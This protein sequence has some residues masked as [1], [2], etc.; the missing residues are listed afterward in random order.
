ML[1]RIG[2]GVHALA[3]TTGL[4]PPA[5]PRGDHAR[6]RGCRGEPPCRGLGLGL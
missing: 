2:R 1:R 6:G 5:P 4:G 3:G